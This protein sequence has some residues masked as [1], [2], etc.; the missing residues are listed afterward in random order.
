MRLS[1]AVRKMPA[2]PVPYPGQSL[3]DYKTVLAWHSKK[4]D[5][6]EREYADVLTQGDR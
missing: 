2:W 4:L 1:E 6:W 3:E 5:Q